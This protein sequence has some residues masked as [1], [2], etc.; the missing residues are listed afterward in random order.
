MGTLKE[1]KRMFREDPEL[2]KM[3][4]RANRH[5]IMIDLNGDDIADITIMDNNRDG[6]IDMIGVDT[7]RDGDF[8]FYVGDMDCNGIIDTVEFY[9]DNEDMPTASYF[10]KT[11]EEYFMGKA[12]KILTPIYTAK[13]IA[14]DLINAMVEFE[15]IAAE[16]YRKVIENK[17]K[18][19]SDAAADNKEN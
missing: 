8:N 5:E 2:M 16:E 1:A 9:E 7:T 14:A 3:V 17:D 13:F 4:V 6:D 12:E 18:A 11:V 19:A 15:A 10:G